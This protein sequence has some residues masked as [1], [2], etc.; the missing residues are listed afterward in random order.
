MNLDS[1]RKIVGQIRELF[2]FGGGYLGPLETSSPP[3][4]GQILAMCL[5]E[6]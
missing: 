3:P 5:A 4:L 6:G 2:S 1:S